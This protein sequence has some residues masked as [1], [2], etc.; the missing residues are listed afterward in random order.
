[1]SLLVQMLFAEDCRALTGTSKR[2]FYETLE[3]KSRVVDMRAF[4][5]GQ[6][7]PKGAL[8]LMISDFRGGLL[9]QLRESLVSAVSENLPRETEQRRRKQLPKSRLRRQ[10]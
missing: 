6:T 9:I 2:E 1:M 7:K 8:M 3:Q 5:S 10:R 4:V